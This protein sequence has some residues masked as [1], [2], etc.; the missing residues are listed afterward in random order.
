MIDVGSGVRAKLPRASD[1]LNE[2]DWLTIEYMR[3]NPYHFDVDFDRAAMQYGVTVDVKPTPLSLAVIFGEVLHDLRSALDHTARLLV[4]ADH[5][6]PEL[7]PLWLLQVLKNT[8]KHRL[9]NVTALVGS[10]GAA[11]VPAP[12]DPNRATT[13]EQRRHLVQ[14]V[15]GLRQV[16]DVAEDE[17]FKPATI[18]GLW[19]YT[20]G[21]AGP[22]AG[23][24]NQLV[25]TGR[26]LAIHIAEHVLPRFGEF[27]HT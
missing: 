22:N 3:D 16:F 12:L 19:G 2:L 15:P 9:L 7:N 11:F 5:K 8:D 17:V 6:E 13:H 21:L 27:F 14:L 4:Q 23:Y 18:A 26:T 25:G 1:L 24:S 10:G 20:V